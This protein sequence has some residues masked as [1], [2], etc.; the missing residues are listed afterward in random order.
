MSISCSTCA[1]VSFQQAP[2]SGASLAVDGGY[3]SILLSVR[4]HA[5][6]P[7]IVVRRSKH[8]LGTIYTIDWC[9]EL[10]DLGHL[11]KSSD[12]VLIVWFWFS[13]PVNVT[14]PVCNIDHLY[15]RKSFALSKKAGCP[16]LQQSCDWEGGR[17]REPLYQS[18]QCK[19][20]W[21]PAIIPHSY[22]Q[23]I[24]L[25]FLILLEQEKSFVAQ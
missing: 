23:S 22:K 15:S 17:K 14:K 19:L 5:L 13:L 10:L 4:K 8:R 20:K 11:R 12:H 7:G 21:R 1:S 9:L 16:C 24:Y 6:L 18:A 3:R 25:S 2:F